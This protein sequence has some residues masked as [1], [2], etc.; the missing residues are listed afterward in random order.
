MGNFLSSGLSFYRVNAQ[1][2]SLGKFKSRFTLFAF[3]ILTVVSFSQ[4]ASALD[5][6]GIESD[7]YLIKSLADFD[8]FAGNK[9]YWND[10]IRLETDIDLAGRTYTQAPIAPDTSSDISFQGTS[11]AGVFDGNDNTISNLKIDTAGASNDYL[12]L[13]GYIDAG[14]E[15]KNLGIEDVNMTGGEI[16]CSFGGLCGRSS[17]TITNCYATGSITGGNNSSFLG[18]L[19]GWNYYGTITNC[20]SIGSVKGDTYIGGL[21]GWNFFGSSITD[22]YANGYVGGGN[23]SYAVGGLVGCNE[24]STI[25]NCHTNSVVTG[26]DNSYAVGGL[27]GEQEEGDISNCY[28]AGSVNAGDAVGNLVGRNYY[29]SINNCYSTGTVSGESYSIGGLVGYNYF[30][31]I[32]NCYAAD[33]V[34]GRDNSG[35]LGGLVG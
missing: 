20:Y 27:V 18:G 7:P 19:C 23:S 29:G 17:G 16:S 35:R 9:N 15:V 3:V 11:F 32:N 1:L 2:K 34:S 33:S 24:N 30:G 21:V 10:Y 14:G 12:G 22:C 31:N 13:F 28:A 25:N 26:E 5:G 8:E 4:S 6:A